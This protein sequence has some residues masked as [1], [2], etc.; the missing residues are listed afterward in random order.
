MMTSGVGVGVVVV[1]EEEDEEEEEEDL[2]GGSAGRSTF[3][4]DLGGYEK[5]DGEMTVAVAAVGP[6][7]SSKPKWRSE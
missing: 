1:V 2:S 5:V 3:A 7:V 4:D 6:E